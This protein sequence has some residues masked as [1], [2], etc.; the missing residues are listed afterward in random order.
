LERR[1]I[2]LA[3]ALTL[4]LALYGIPF[5]YAATTSTQSTYTVTKELTIPA[6]SLNALVNLRCLNPTDYTDHFSTNPSN[7]TDVHV[8][9]SLLLSSSGATAATGDNPNGWEIDLQN[10]YSG[11]LVATVQIV[12]QTPVTVSVAGIGVPEFGSLYVAIALGAVLYFLMARRFARRPTL[13]AQA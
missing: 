9:G 4:P 3:L 6:G 12:C 2:V 8:R 1:A 13:S 10:S 11:D 5:A 7:P